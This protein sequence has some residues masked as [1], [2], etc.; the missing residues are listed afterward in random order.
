MMKLSIALIAT[1]ALA[2]CKTTTSPGSNNNTPDTG[3]S[4]YGANYLPL[5]DNT[6][7][8]SHLT[9]TSYYFDRNGNVTETNQFDND[10]RGDIGFVT[11]RNGLTVHPLFGFDGPGPNDFSNHGNPVGYGGFLNGAFIALDQSTQDPNNIGTVLPKV[12]TVGQ[13]WN[14]APAGSNIQCQGK[15]VEH[16][17][18]FTTKGG[19]SFTDVIHIYA[20]YLDSSGIPL[21]NERKYSGGADL[22]FANGIGI[23]EADMNYMEHLNYNLSNGNSFEHFT[24][25]GTG[26]RN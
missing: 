7:M 17:S 19:T 6:M 20:T 11:T 3:T 26:W 5:V 15:F 18:Q 14:G 13:S 4:V 10:Q 25:S 9:G 21:I 22:Y 8:S 23:I 16:F 2:S 24:L 12:L 1:L